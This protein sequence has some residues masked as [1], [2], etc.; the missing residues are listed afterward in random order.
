[1]IPMSVEVTIAEESGNQISLQTL[2]GTAR[3]SDG[4]SVESFNIHGPVTRFP[5]GHE[6]H[7]MSGEPRESQKSSFR[8]QK[9]PT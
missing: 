3:T 8:C 5:L 1:M 9:P 2:R 6:L 7:G 4:L